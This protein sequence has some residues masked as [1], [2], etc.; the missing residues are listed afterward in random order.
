VGYSQGA[1]ILHMALA[2]VDKA[3]LERVVAIAVYGDPGQ[4][5]TGTA[6][7]P[8]PAFPEGFAGKV[9]WNCAAGD[10]ACD[11]DSKG[12]FT[13]HLTYA[14]KGAIWEGQSARFIAAAFKGEALP[15]VV[16]K[17]VAAPKGS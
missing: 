14:N 1:R 8:T 16:N 3:V 4:K 15:E 9:V 17:P 13:A 11:V 10:P 7:R 12:D 2:K 5:G 6:E